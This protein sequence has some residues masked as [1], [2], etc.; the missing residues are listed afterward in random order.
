MSKDA[1][2]VLIQSIREG[3]PHNILKF[4]IYACFKFMFWEV[5]S[6]SYTIRNIRLFNQQL[7]SHRRSQFKSR[8]VSWASSVELVETTS[9]FN[10]PTKLFLEMFMKEKNW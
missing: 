9:V 4:N 7:I 1:C 6:N 10:N 2:Y 8:F 3:Y 5:L